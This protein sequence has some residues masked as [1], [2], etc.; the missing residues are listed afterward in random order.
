MSTQTSTDIFHLDKYQ[1]FS[2]H[3]IAYKTFFEH[4][5]ST[6]YCIFGLDILPSKFS[7]SIKWVGPSHFPEAFKQ[8]MGVSGWQG[9]S[10]P[11]EFHVEAVICSRHGTHA[12]YLSAHLKIEIESHNVIIKVIFHFLPWPLQILPSLA[13]DYYWHI[14]NNV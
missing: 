6:E 9:G 10:L 4:F 8:R 3:V 13:K 14:Q 5:L 7:E 12:A 2:F 1:H 11:F